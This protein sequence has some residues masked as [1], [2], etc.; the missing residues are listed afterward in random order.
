MYVQWKG[1]SIVESGRADKLTR[2]A[3][4]S[5]AKYQERTAAVCD[6]GLQIVQRCID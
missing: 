1:M 5:V 3:G 6:V 2:N 4:N